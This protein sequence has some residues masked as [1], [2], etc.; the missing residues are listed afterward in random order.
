[1]EVYLSCNNFRFTLTFKESEFQAAD[2]HGNL[3]F[4]ARQKSV[5]ADFRRRCRC[6]WVGA[7]EKVTSKNPI[8]EELRNTGNLGN[9]I[10]EN[11]TLWLLKISRIT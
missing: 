11:F 1:V 7:S 9:F 5:K 10:F 8:E 6:A 2:G 3:L 4:L